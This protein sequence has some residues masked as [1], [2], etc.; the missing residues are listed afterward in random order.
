MIQR[1]GYL[2]VKIK[3]VNYSPKYQKK[4]RKDS[5]YII[6]SERDESTIDTA[7]IQRIIGNY[8]KNHIQI[9]WRI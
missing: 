3:L 8:L 4:E 6:R 7:E 1:V 2:K 9:N 5:Y